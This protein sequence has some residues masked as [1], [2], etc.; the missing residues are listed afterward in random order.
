[1]LPG[2]SSVSQTESLSKAATGSPFLIYAIFARKY[3]LDPDRFLMSKLG[4]KFDGWS[5]LPL[6]RQE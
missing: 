4:R 5:G 1:M 2:L 6:K 3:D